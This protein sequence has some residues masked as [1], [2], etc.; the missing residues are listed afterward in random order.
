VARKAK[1]PAKKGR[2]K[3]RSSRN[4]P[5]QKKVKAHAKRAKSRADSRSLPQRRKASGKPAKVLSADRSRPTTSRSAA[6]SRTAKA[7]R[8][9]DG[10]TK[11]AGPRGKSKQSTSRRPTS[12]GRNAR[13][14]AK[15]QRRINE[16]WKE[17][18]AKLKASADAIRQRDEVIRD[19]TRTPKEGR[20]TKLSSAEAAKEREPEANPLPKKYRDTYGKEGKSTG[21]IK[22]Y[23]GDEWEEIEWKKH[24]DFELWELAEELVGEEDDDDLYGG[25]DA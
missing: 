2:A 23:T 21:G 9:S 19:L 12:S 14:I 22:S 3:S 24:A 7:S 6:N 11:R 5:K 17:S 1:K 4:G 10:S 16:Q 13:T 20:H 18:Q 8:R 15:L 25:N